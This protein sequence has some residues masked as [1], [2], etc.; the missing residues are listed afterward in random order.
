MTPPKT[1]IRF[2]AIRVFHWAL[3]G[4]LGRGRDALDGGSSGGLVQAPSAQPLGNV[5][6]GKK[7]VEAQAR[8]DG[9][10]VSAHG[11]VIIAQRREVVLCRADLVG[12][13]RCGVEEQKLL[14]D[15]PRG[16]VEDHDTML[17]DEGND[18]RVHRS[19]VDPCRAGDGFAVQVAIGH[20]L[21][22]GVGATSQTRRS[23]SL[24]IP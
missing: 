17:L 13:I 5:F 6:E 9:A 4:R 2:G 16:R 22:D 24:N 12:G 8:D 19:V 7:E 3:S 15:G 11:S 1:R 14:L 21:D 23:W 20:R 18:G 10:E